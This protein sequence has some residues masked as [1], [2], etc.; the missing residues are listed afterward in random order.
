MLWTVHASEVQFRTESALRARD[1]AIRAARSERA[2]AVAQEIAAGIDR[3]RPGRPAAWPRPIR[4][5]P[6]Q[7]ACA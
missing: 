7:P 4:L 1:L 6:A 3:T 2:A 5:A